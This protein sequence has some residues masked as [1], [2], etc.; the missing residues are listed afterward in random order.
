MD[1]DGD[2]ICDDGLPYTGST[3]VSGDALYIGN[4]GSGRA[5]HAVSGADTALWAQS[6]TGVGVDA[7]SDLGV[8]LVAT[9]NGSDGIQGVASAAAKSGVY[10]QSSNSGGYGVVGRNTS[11]GSFGGLGYG[12]FGLYAESTGPYAYAVF[13]RASGSTASGYFS[14]DV[15]IGGNLNVTGTKNFR[16]DHPFDP[17]ESYLVHAA[18]ESSEVLNQYSGT[19]ILDENGTVV[20]E[21]ESW[22]GAINTDLR[23]QLTAIGGA[24][25][26][27]HISREVVDNRFEIAGGPPGIKV[28]WQITARRNDAYM[29]QHPFEVEVPKT[30]IESGTY[31][32]PECHGQPESASTETAILTAM[33]PRRPTNDEQQ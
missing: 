3:T 12:S 33:G 7:R 20:I 13:A 17:S 25:P 21:L 24:A 16:I 30:G 4:T 32:C 5:I 11:S 26:N 19:A 6:S 29:R 22:F 10:G 28:S 8:A 2:G 1:A 23:Y 27:L 18:V 15:N 14:A 31:L 9:S